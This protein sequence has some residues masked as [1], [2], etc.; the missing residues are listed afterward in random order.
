MMFQ[1][2]LF[3]VPVLTP[4]HPTGKQ[5]VDKNRCLPQMRAVVPVHPFNEHLQNCVGTAI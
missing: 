2:L 1:V 5:Q 4:V 3:P